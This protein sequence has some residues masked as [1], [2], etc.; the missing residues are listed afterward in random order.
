MIVTYEDVGHAR[1]WAWNGLLNKSV[2]QN[3]SKRHQ[4][5]KETRMNW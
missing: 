2:M 1:I 4:L 5:N 3:S